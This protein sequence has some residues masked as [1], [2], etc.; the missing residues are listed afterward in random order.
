MEWSMCLIPKNKASPDLKNSTF[1]LRAHSLVFEVSERN[2]LSG[3]SR[4]GA[5]TSV[6]DGHDVQ[7]TW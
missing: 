7:V 6:E 5:V 2:V 4:K 3:T 1:T